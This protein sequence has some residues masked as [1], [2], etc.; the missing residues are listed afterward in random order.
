M[1]FTVK[2]VN[3][4]KFAVVDE[5]DETVIIKKSKGSA[6]KLARAMVLGSGFNGEIPAFF[7]PQT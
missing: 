2:E 4:K 6:R 3:S 1:T 5:N 7:Y